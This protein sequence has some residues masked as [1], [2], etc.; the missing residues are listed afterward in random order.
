MDMKLFLEMKIRKFV[1]CRNLVYIYYFF[2]YLIY[3]LPYE[4]YEVTKREVYNDNCK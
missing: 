1:S 4:S 2:L 3:N